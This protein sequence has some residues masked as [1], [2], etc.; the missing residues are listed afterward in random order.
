[1]DSRINRIRAIPIDV[2]ILASLIVYEI[3]RSSL[4]EQ[5]CVCRSNNEETCIFYK[6]IKYFCLIRIISTMEIFRE[7]KKIIQ[8]LVHS[9]RSPQRIPISDT[10]FHLSLSTPESFCSKIKTSERSS[11]CHV[12]ILLK[13]ANIKSLETVEKR[14]KE[15]SRCVRDW[16]RVEKSKG[17]TGRRPFSP[18]V[19]LLFFFLPS[20]TVSNLNEPRLT[21]RPVLSGPWIE[22]NGTEGLLNDNGQLVRAG[23]YFRCNVADI[24]HRVGASP[25]PSNQPA[26]IFPTMKKKDNDATIAISFHARVSSLFLSLFLSPKNRRR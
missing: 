18:F 14:R 4:F 12:E 24:V 10:A 19:H 9:C 13:S 2:S 16:T 25:P 6:K 3:P 21:S 8:R 22:S 23:S 5:F 20:R 17:W 26:L 1:M 11:F 15:R 7:W